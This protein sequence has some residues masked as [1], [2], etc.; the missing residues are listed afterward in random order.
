MREVYKRFAGFPEFTQ[1]S[2]S[3][4]SLRVAGRSRVYR[5]LVL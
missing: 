1:L 2:C 3:S 4:V 5:N